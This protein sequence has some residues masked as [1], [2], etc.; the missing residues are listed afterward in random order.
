MLESLRP[1]TI[2][3]TSIELTGRC[4]TLVL[5][6]ERLPMLKDYFN[7]DMSIELKMKSSPPEV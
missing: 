5:A 1:A 6:A 2:V 7:A 4:K 3:V